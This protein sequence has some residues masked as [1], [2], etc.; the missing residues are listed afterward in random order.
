MIK[1]LLC[2]LGFHRYKNKGISLGDGDTFFNGEFECNR[3][4]KVIK[5]KPGMTSFELMV[6]MIIFFIGMYIV[7]TTIMFPNS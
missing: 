1:K 6:L 7:Y 3:C 4:G 2:K 5:K